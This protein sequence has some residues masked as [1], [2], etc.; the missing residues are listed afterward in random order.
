MFFCD[1]KLYQT[2]ISKAFLNAIDPDK[3]RDRLLDLVIR[4][5]ELRGD[6]CTL[7][8]LEAFDTCFLILS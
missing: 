6:V 5:Q 3:E 8:E 1:T 4:E 7:I 2:V